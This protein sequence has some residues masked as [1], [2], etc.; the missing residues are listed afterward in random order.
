ME[1][2][3][4]FQCGMSQHIPPCLCINS[5]QDEV[6]PA[7]AIQ[8]HFLSSPV[9][10]SSAPQDTVDFQSFQKRSLLG[11]CKKKVIVGN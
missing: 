5:S 2:S 4:C 9:G 8:L 10:L 1:S 6:S 7:L 3:H 11:S